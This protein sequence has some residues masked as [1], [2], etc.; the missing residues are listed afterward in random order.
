MLKSK[1]IAWLNGDKNKSLAGY[2]RP[3]LDLK[4]H[5]Y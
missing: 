3:T 1:D 2:K 4:T 5:T